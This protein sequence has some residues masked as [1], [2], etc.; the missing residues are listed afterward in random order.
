MNEIYIN[1]RFQRQRCTGVQRVAKEISCLLQAPAKQIIP[2]Y[3]YQGMAGH[4][5]EQTVLP[6]HV[7][8]GAL[9]SPCNTGPMAVR[10]QIVTIH[11]MAVFEHPQW[12]SGNFSRLYHFLLPRLAR[13]VAKI[14]TDSNFSRN[15]ISHFLAVEPAKIEVVYPGVSK[16]FSPRSPSEIEMAKKS[17][18][19]GGQ[20]Y[21]ITLGTQE[22]RKNLKHV[23]KVWREI[24][25]Q[26]GSGA[27][28]LIVGGVTKAV[29]QSAD[30]VVLPPNVIV[31]GYVADS[32]L[33]ALLSGAE[34]LLYPSLYEGFG[35]PVIEGMACGTPVIT[36][37]CASLPE[38]GG[39]AALY[40]DANSPEEMK[41]I[42][43][44]LLV[45]PAMRE[46]IAYRGR[47]QAAA[48]TWERSAANMDALLQMI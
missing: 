23:F 13:R 42:M 8:D 3:L 27:K 44:Q 16:R 39:D 22:P 28:L 31:A 35:L 33:L 37:R 47:E 40:V 26:L 43:L 36:T 18:G 48:F 17:Y 21:F 38:A 10:R 4:L 29:F 20:K 32:T 19:L 6:L 14:V 7:R 5:W 34:A 24:T 25:E 11:D 41:K 30:A 46:D 12:F 45:E 9:W 1:G 15:R 2:H